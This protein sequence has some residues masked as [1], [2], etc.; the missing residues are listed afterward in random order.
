MLISVEFTRFIPNKSAFIRHFYVRLRMKIKKTP[1]TFSDISLKTVKTGIRFCIP[2]KL[3]YFI[4]TSDYF[5]RSLSK[6]L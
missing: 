6:K 1:I 3:V 4:K 2:L 5:L